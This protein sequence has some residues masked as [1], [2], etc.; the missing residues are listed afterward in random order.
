MKPIEP[1]SLFCS[2][3]LLAVASM[4]TA[5]LGCMP[6]ES[7]KPTGPPVNIEGIASEALL[8]TDAS[9]SGVSVSGS[10]LARSSTP[11]YIAVYLREMSPIVSYLEVT[12]DGRLA[13]GVAL[14][15]NVEMVG[16]VN[17]D[18]YSLRNMERG[19][20]VGNIALDVT[21]VDGQLL[22]IHTVPVPK[23]TKLASVFL[24]VT[25]QLS[26]GDRIGDVKISVKTQ[27]M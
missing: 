2:V 15:A 18:R 14:A 3:L 7:S 9:E 16:D 8:F 13:D 20:V 6:S 23:G 21:S 10:F 5:L 22:A 26:S 24:F 25:S 27:E 12:I 4:S 1:I 17:D 11:R 19:G